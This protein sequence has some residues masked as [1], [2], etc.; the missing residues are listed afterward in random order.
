MRSFP[1]TRSNLIVLLLPFPRSIQCFSEFMEV[2]IGDDVDAFSKSF[3]RMFKSV[4]EGLI[5]RD[6]H[7]SWVDV[8]CDSQLGLGFFKKA[9]RKLGWGCCSTDAIVLGSYM[10]PFGLIYPRIGL[11]F[12]CEA[13]LG[14]AAL[15]LE[16]SDVRG[17]SLSCKCCDLEVFAVSG[18]SG[19]VGNFGL[20]GNDSTSIR[21]MKIWRQTEAAKIDGKINGIVL[22]HG[23][24]VKCDKDGGRES[25]CEFFVDR[26]LEM[27]HGEKPGSPV[28]LIFLAFLY[29]GN[30]SALVSVS[31]KDGKSTRFGLLKPFLVHSAVLSIYDSAPVSS[32]DDSSVGHLK[33]CCDIS[34]FQSQDS[35]L[36]NAPKDADDRRRKNK[37]AS[38][39]PLDLNWSSFCEAVLSQS[40]DL[41]INDV[42]PRIQLEDVY[43]SKKYS[44]S[45]KLR[46]LKCWIKQITK[47]GSDCQIEPYKQKDEVSVQEGTEERATRLDEDAELS[48]TSSPL[49]GENSFSGSRNEEAPEFSHPDNLEDFLSTI[50]QKIHHGLCCEDVDLGGFAERLVGLSI[51]CLYQNYQKKD[52]DDLIFSK[53]DENCGAKVADELV[54]LLLTK[55]KDLVVKY[56]GSSP[57]LTSDPNPTIKTSR[58]KLREH[59]LQI[60][61]RM[62]ILKSRVG[63]NIEKDLKHKMVK[64]ICSLLGNIEFNLQGGIFGGESLVDFAGRII[65]KR[66]TQSLRDVISK[67]YT[68]M[69]FF[70]FN[71]GDE[72]NSLPNS[73]DSDGIHR[74]DNRDISRSSFCR[75]SLAARESSPDSPRNDVDDSQ[76]DQDNLNW[77]TK[78]QE[79]RNRARRFSSFTS[80]TPDL[81]R[82]WAP[83]LPNTTK[84]TPE[85]SCK[86]SKRRKRHTARYDMV[87]ETPMTDKKPRHPEIESSRSLSKA[88]FQERN[89]SDDTKQ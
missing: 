39:L 33:E 41:T 36:L 16:I 67:I 22:L 81:L 2:E 40:S 62:E 84:A 46:F 76:Q 29:K 24:P 27:L 52:T 9:I 11:N 6:I 53:T 42:D 49:I 75:N 43:F 72:E 57:L 17:N 20:F 89:P 19:Q 28:W 48:V 31:D 18:V 55:P 77:I 10:V 71:E 5:S 15:V 88:L 58:D 32:I 45:K 12:E 4:S 26:V 69:E 65:K 86:P 37:K 56:K 44:N 73:N 51:H 83:R 50:T 25:S 54:G 59:E 82:V 87:C 30:Y 78:A 14:S 80:W 79:R 68:K 61:F 7:F 34:P 60:L 85:S 8:S 74:D 64:E 3:S 13:R 21:V 35:C 23:V 1:I 63:T 70:P 66:Y 47:L 38:N